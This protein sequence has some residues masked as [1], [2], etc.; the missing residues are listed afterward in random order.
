ML[1]SAYVHRIITESVGDEVIA[2]G[3]EFSHGGVTHVVNANEEVIL[4]AGYVAIMTILVLIV[5]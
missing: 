4:S 5:H 3:V 2:K 1:V